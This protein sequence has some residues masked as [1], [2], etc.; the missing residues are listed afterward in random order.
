MVLHVNVANLDLLFIDEL[1]TKMNLL[2]NL[3]FAFLVFLLSAVV[4]AVVLASLKPIFCDFPWRRRAR[5][6]YLH[7]KR[8]WKRAKRWWKKDWNTK[9]TD[10]D[11]NLEKKWKFIVE[12]WLR[13]IISTFVLLGFVITFYFLVRCVFGLDLLDYLPDNSRTWFVFVTRPLLVAFVAFVVVV[14]VRACA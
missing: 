7:A 12:R 10:I 9:F 14:V 6:C 3:I 5:L 2:W 8:R 1:G 13:I 11:T 4:L